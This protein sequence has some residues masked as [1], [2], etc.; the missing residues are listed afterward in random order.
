MCSVGQ[1]GSARRVA[2][3]EGG[4]LVTFV[5][6]IS[7]ISLYVVVGMET[8]NKIKQTNQSVQDNFTFLSKSSNS[9][10]VQGRQLF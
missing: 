3:G 1:G 10:V 5:H 9:L 2:G 7:R 8:K 6:R 4:G